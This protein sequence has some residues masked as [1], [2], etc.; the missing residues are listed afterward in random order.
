VTGHYNC[1]GIRAALQSQEL[2]LIDNW[3]RNVRDV[4]RL[5][6]DELMSIADENARGRRLVELNVL[7]Q[8]MN[9]LKTGMIPADQHHHEPLSR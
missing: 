3:L 9:V 1:G 8:A 5:Y 4:A 6:Q 7:E 2:G